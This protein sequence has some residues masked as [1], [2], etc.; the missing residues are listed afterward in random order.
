MRVALLVLVAAVVATAAVPGAGALDII[1]EPK[2]L[3]DGVVGIPY[4]HEFEGEE[5]CPPSYK[6][7]VRSDSQL[8]PGL[9]LETD[10]DLVGTP[11]LPGDWTFWVH[12][13]DGSGPGACNST[14]SQADFNIRILPAL[15]IASNLPGTVAGRP[16]NTQLVG[17]GGAPLIWSV[18]A[19]ALPPGLSLSDKGVFSGATSA[20]GTY[21]F[22]IRLQDIGPKRVTTKQFTYVVANPLSVTPPASRP[23]EVGRPLSF[24]PTVA[25]GIPPLRWSL[26][27]GTTLPGG[28]TL[29]ATTGAVTGTPSAAGSFPLSLTVADAEGTVVP[30]TAQLTV[31]PRLAI[32]TARL[33][34]ATVGRRYAATLKTQGGVSPV[35]WRIARGALP[36]GLRF[37]AT[38]KI[39]GTARAVGRRSV[40]IQATDA[41][42]A[43]ATKT[44]V[45][46]AGRT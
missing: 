15:A 22:T 7:E 46:R 16:V 27:G 36:R 37:D 9:V 12:L 14:P 26:A 44:L 31:A 4:H 20:V 34:G 21:S 2:T 24:T 11:T 45:V 23:A 43:T 25:G 17:T 38:G 13:S 28:L 40:T 42:G 19:G 29:N 30:L 39:T 6:F 35:R 3:A 32:A 10:G 18:S 1:S 8:P 5:G 41:L 33:T